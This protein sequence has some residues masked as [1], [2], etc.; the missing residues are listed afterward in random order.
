MNKFDQN[1]QCDE[2]QDFRPSAEDWAEY[3]LWLDGELEDDSD[4]AHD[5]EQDRQ[6]HG[7]IWA[8]HF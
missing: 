2:L 6:A 3:E 8:D 1:V 4:M 5:L 7:G